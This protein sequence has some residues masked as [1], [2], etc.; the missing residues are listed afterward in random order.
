[1]IKKILLILLVI[2]VVIQ[3]FHPA[4]NQ[5]SGEQPNSIARVYTVSPEVKT[6]LDKACMDCHSNNTIY[7]WYS[8]IQPV[9][10][11]MDNHIREGKH[12]LNFDEFA[13]YSPRRQYRKLEQ[14][15]KQVKEGEMPLNSYTWIHKN[16]ILTDAEKATLTQ[17]AQGIRTNLEGKYPADSLSPPKRPGEGPGG[18]PHQ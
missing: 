16:A 1:M 17:W 11:W 14:V 4:K 8:K 3:F 5:A 2:L 12:D 13:S 15:M 9:D 7:P 10:W 18:E 6:I